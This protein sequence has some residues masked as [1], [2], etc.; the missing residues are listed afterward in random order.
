MVYMKGNPTVPMCGFSAQVVGFLK[1][2][3]IDFSS[4]NVL[5]YPSIREG[6]KKF[7]Q[8][9]T[10]PQVYVDGEFIGGCD[11]ITEMHNSGELGDLLKKEPEK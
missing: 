3:G 11:I 9:P 2:E 4:V 5:D 7:S 1:A 10:I 6:I 8:W